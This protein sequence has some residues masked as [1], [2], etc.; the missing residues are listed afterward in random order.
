V[1]PKIEAILSH[2]SE[3]ERGA[4]PGLIAGLAPDVR[5]RLLGTEWYSRAAP[6]V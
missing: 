5:A 2:H 3:I 6:A 1:A 4:L